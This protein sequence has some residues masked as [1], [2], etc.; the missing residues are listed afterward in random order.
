MNIVLFR[1]TKF[2]DLVE[3]SENIY[4]LFLIDI[5]RISDYANIFNPKR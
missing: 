3:N 2:N 1:F 4:S 5:S